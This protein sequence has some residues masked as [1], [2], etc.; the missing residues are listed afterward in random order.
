VTISLAGLG[1]RARREINRTLEWKMETIIFKAE[2]VSVESSPSTS[3]VTVTVEANARDVVEDLC[4]SDRLHEVSPRDIIDEVGST[5]LLQAF[6]EEEL[7]M[8]VR[9][10]LTDP[11]DLLSAIGL[12]AI[13]EYLSHGESDRDLPN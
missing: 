9:D 8:W 11:T 1:D 2:S 7:S 6:D 12:D 4:V 13:H 10:A 5:T 3:A